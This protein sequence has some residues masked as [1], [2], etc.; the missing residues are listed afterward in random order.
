MVMIASKQPITNLVSMWSWIYLNSK[1]MLKM[2]KEKK[3]QN[4]RFSMRMKMINNQPL[5]DRL[6]T[7]KSMKIFTPITKN[8]LNPQLKSSILENKMTS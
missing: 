7:S 6:R 3:T 2:I 5:K 8:L 1:K 4:R